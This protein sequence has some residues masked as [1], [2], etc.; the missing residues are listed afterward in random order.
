MSGDAFPPGF[1]PMLADKLPDGALPA[2]PCL[3]S[4]KLDGVRCVIGAD[5]VAYSRKLK[6][7]P[8]RWVQKLFG[9]EGYAGLDGE[10]IVGP[11]TGKD[12]FRDTM[13]GVMSEDG[14]PD[15]FFH[16]FDRFRWEPKRFPVPAA[17][18]NC[19]HLSF[20]T[21]LAGVGEVNRPRVVLV[22]HSMCPDEKTLLAREQGFLAAGYEGLMIRSSGGPYKF[23]RSTVREGYLLKLKRFSDAE[24]VVI[25]FEELQH[26]E[27]VQERDALGHAKRSTKKAG[28]VG[29]GMLGTLLCRDEI[30][31]IEFGIGGGFTEEMRR[32]FWEV[33]KALLG[34]LV[35]Y[36]FFPTGS[37][38][39]PRFPTFKNFRDRRDT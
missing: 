3:V 2:F 7:I 30:T 25:G 28:K 1:K 6:A 8:N 20:V 35:T 31:G 10:L 9:K 21:R 15:V 32:E 26:N 14:K 36:K 5:G 29:A 22:S 23:G 34:R 24:A 4:P 39:A 16:V 11:A 17:N 19:Q 18:E 13:S 27:N 38:E 12:A 33:R 37:K